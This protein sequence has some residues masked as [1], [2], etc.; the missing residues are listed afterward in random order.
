MPTICNQ[1]LPMFGGDNTVAGLPSIPGIFSE[2]PIA[3][4]LGKYRCARVRLIRATW[5]PLL[6]SASLQIRPCSR[7]MRRTEKYCGLIRLIDPMGGLLTG[8]P[9]ISKPMIHPF[10]GGVASVE[11]AAAVTPDVSATFPRNCSK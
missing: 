9:R 2:C 6:F 7:G 8:L 11:I 3:S 5:A 10:R 1:E 4:P